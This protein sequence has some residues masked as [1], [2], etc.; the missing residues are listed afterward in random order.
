MFYFYVQVSLSTS[1]MGGAATVS[2][3]AVRYVEGGQI[4]TLESSMVF[5]VNI[6]IFRNP[7]MQVF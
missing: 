6:Y 5:E 3:S 4:T 1:A 2:L 7:P